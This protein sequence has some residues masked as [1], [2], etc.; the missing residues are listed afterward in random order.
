MVTVVMVVSVVTRIAV[1][2][3]QEV[4]TRAGATE[5]RASFRVVEEAA[6]RLSVENNPRPEDALPGIVP[7]PLVEKL[8]AGFSF[9]RERYQ[10]DWENWTLPGGMPN[11]PTTEG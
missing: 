9:D 6:T 8:P 5:I 1:P 4:L 11:D 3:M 10:L 7:E 2:Q